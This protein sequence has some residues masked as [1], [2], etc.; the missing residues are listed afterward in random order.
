MRVSRLRGWGLTAASLMICS[1]VVSH[2]L[3]R[4][5]APHAH[6]LE[7]R[8]LEQLSYEVVARQRRGDHNGAVR[9]AKIMSERV[10]ARF[11]SG[12]PQYALA[13][14]N[15]GL[16]WMSRPAR[17]TRNRITDARRKS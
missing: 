17:T 9:L 3:S 11:G 14:S 7:Q 5:G 1:F 16:C 2:P 10:K 6:A 4:F 8:S 15:I 12:H 13:L